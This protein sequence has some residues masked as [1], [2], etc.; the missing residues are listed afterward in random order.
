MATDLTLEFLEGGA[1][2]NAGA[3]RSSCPY[4]A[5]S[6]AAEAWHA[7]HAWHSY[8]R[9]CNAIDR[10]T[11]GR[12]SRVTLRTANGRAIAAM[13]DWEAPGAPVSFPAIA[14]DRELYET[15]LRAA[16]P[17]QSCGKPVEDAGH[18][19]LFVA[20]NEPALF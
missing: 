16:A 9:S 18:L 14:T 1:A 15:G 7:G 17:L 4:Y 5:T 2:A 19:P 20:A 11:N 6:N 3:D 13:I 12:G 10:V 8:G